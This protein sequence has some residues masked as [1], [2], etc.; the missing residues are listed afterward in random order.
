MYEKILAPLDGSKLGEA[1]IPCIEELVSKIKPGIKVEVTLLQV[2][3]SVAYSVVAG[4][5]IA[6]VPYTDME[7][8]QIEN[9]AKEYIER[10]G[11]NLRSKGA[12]VIPRLEVGNAA[13]EILRVA[14]ETG[15]DL[16]AMSTRGRSGISRWAFGS[17]TGKVLRAARIPVLVVRAPGDTPKI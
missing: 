11:E 16:I 6:P 12:V 9:R 15:I 17:V 8:E 10:V 13:E 1:A 14:E 7:M 4:E 3:S 5:A 2:I